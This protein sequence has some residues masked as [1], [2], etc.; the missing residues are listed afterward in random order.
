MA[1]NGV[2][3]TAGHCAVGTSSD[4]WCHENTLPDDF[5]QIEFN[6]PESLPDGYPQAASPEDT[7]QIK[8]GS[9]VCHYQHYKQG[10]ISDTDGRC[11][12]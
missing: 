11:S 5:I 12:Q 4:G 2:M 7:Y 1:P 9:V 6:V 10:Y 3:V 8:R